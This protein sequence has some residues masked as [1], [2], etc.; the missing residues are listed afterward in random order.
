VLHWQPDD[1][2]LRA[3][4]YH[5]PVHRLVEVVA[6]C[7]SYRALP[8]LWRFV[9]P[10]TDETGKQWFPA[11]GSGSFFHPGGMICAPWS[12]LAY[13]EHDGPHDNWSGPTNWLNV[14]DVT[15]AHTIPDMLA[16]IDVN[17]RQSPGMMA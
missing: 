16:S 15:V 8:P 5:L 6:A 7:D 14:T 4:T 3:A 10:G 11:S 13:K 12:R 2:I 9:R 17:L 1:L